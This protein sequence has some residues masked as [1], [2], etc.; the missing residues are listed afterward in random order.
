MTVQK[1]LIKNA[2]VINEY[3][4][5]ATDVLIVN[6]RIE[7]IA[8]NI[9]ASDDMQIIDARGKHLLPGMIDDQVHFRDPGGEHKADFGTESAAAV[10]GGI[11]SV[12]DMP[13]TNPLTTSQQAIEDKHASI[14]GRAHCNYGFYLGATNDN[15][16]VIKSIDT[17]L[18]CGIKAFMGASTGN[19]LVDNENTLNEIF[20]HAPVLV[21]THCEDTPIIVA[22]EAKAHN[23]YG[24]NIP[25]AL[26]PYIRSAK[27]CLKSTELATSLAIKHN[28]RL[29]VLHISTGAE[30]NYLASLKSKHNNITAEACVHFLWF[31]EA[32]Y[33]TKGAQ[34]K[35]NPAIKSQEDQDI[36]FAGINNKTLD[37][38]ATDHAPHLLTEKALDYM[39]SPSGLPLVQTALPSLLSLVKQGKLNLHQTVDQVSHRVADMFNVVD[40]GYI[41]EGYF[42]DLVLIDMD[43]NYQIKNEDMLYKCAWTPYD[44]A[45]FSAIVE[46]TWVNGQ[47]K[48]ADNRIQNSPIGLAL[49]YDRR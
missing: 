4:S 46:K 18:I 23:Q 43:K 24:D 26:H 8:P 49:Q 33:A 47:L 9:K 22:N 1:T 25:V 31:T 35:C 17:S 20:K 12:M 15:I 38:I 2:L 48:W 37:V 6:E 7:T 41:R 30:V 45:Q 42:A 13:N 10:A 39:H 28:A 27:A 34:I 3:Q 21:A 14:A 11:T 44:G 29:H 36:I 32:D 5:I 40:R 16:E 19:M